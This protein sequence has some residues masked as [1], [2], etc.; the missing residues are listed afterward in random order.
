[1]KNIAHQNYQEA[2][3]AILKRSFLVKMPILENKKDLKWIISVSFIYNYK[4]LNPK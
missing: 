2:T 1:M 3:K 4:K